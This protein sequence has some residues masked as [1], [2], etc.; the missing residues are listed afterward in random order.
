MGERQVATRGWTEP[1]EGQEGGGCS[2][3][4]DF[5]T[6]LPK[7]SPGAC[8]DDDNDDGDDDNYDVDDDDNYDGD[9]GDDGDDG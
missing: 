3:L 5:K 7:T 4:A 1:A 6:L 2:D 8:D 9:D